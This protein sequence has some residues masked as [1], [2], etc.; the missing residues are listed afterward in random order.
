MLQH[1]K[2]DF[3]IGVSIKILTLAVF[4]NLIS[5]QIFAQKK[6]KVEILNANTLEYD[7]NLEK[8]VRRL[9]G[10]VQLKHEDAIMTCDSAYMYTETNSFDAFGNVHIYQGDS[11]QLFGDSLKYNGNTRKAQLN[12]NVRLIDKDM[13]L[14]SNN[15]NYDLKT[16][17]AY[18]YGGGIIVSNKNNINLKSNQG[19]Y[20]T[21]TKEFFFK[22]K[23]VLKHPQYEMFSDTLKYN[24]FTEITYFYG[25]TRIISDSNL[26]Y[27]ENGWYDTRNDISQYSKNAYLF[28]KEQKLFGDSLH[29][30]RKLGIGKAF[31]NITIIDTIQKIMVNGDYAVHYEKE[32]R[33]IVTGKTMLTLMFDNDSLFLHADTL[34]SVFDSTQTHRTLFAYHKVKFFK[35]DM[36]GKCDSLVYTF[37]DSLIRLFNDPI[38]W[39]DENQLSAEYIEIKMHDG[40][41]EQLEM[42]NMA[43]IISQE[44]TTKFNQ[45]KGKNMTGYFENNQ[46][47]FVDVR[48]DGQTVYYVKEDNGNYIGVNK[49]ESDNIRIYL[50]DKAVKK[51]TFLKKTKA[52]LYPLDQAKEDELRL[53]GFNWRSTIRPKNIEEIFLWQE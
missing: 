47:S 28:S 48:E 9:I 22:D 12:G 20:Y 46:L 32:N 49:A 16:K 19:Y 25:P 24:T 43:F 40:K 8:N 50:E 11:I 27:C 3:T 15:L 17:L 14:T 45:I 36:Q 38:L 51:I 10:N 21:Q 18:Y 33:S 52:T 35:N 23:V 2:Y 30:D 13:M 4:F 5:V 26:I 41:A 39:S 7:E 29:Y 1:Q 37:Q 53:N 6:T 31:K 44:D 42:K 34:L